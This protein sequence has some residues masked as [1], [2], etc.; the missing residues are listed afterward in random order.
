[1]MNVWEATTTR[2][3]V[4]EIPYGV[5]W[6]FSPRILVIREPVR[7]FV[8]K[9]R[10]SEEAVYVIDKTAPR[11]TMYRRADGG[12]YWSAAGV[13]YV[14]FKHDG[15]EY[16]FKPDKTR[17][18]DY[19]VFVDEDTGLEMS[20][21]QIGTAGYTSSDRL[22]VYLLLN[23]AHLALCVTCLW[24]LLG[25]QFWHAVGLGLIMW[26]AATVVVLPGLF[27]QAGAAV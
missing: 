23:L 26:M 4:V 18:E 14:K 10:T 25:F 3:G 6:E 2:L 12:E 8:S 19:I 9:R 1:M 7:E 15:Q 13:E 24:L 27:E 20:E 5:A 21:Y 16:C 11:G 17:D 22:L